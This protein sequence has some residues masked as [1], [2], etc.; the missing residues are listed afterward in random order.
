MARR[1]VRC[2]WLLAV[3]LTHACG[4]SAETDA[5]D[6]AASRP[7]PVDAAL[8]VPRPQDPAPSRLGDP[9]ASAAA[10][11]SWAAG[12]YAPMLQGEV[13]EAL[14][15]A[16]DATAS[17]AAIDRELVVCQADEGP[18]DAAPSPFR[19]VSVRW[20]EDHELDATLERGRRRAY[21]GVPLLSLTSGAVLQ[22]TLTGSDDARELST[23][24]AR[25]PLK[26]RTG[27]LSVEC[28]VVPAKARDE[29]VLDALWKTDKKLAALAVTSTED[30]GDGTSI[31]RAGT[32]A[33]RT[34][35]DAAALV[36]WDDPRVVRRRTR[37]REIQASAGH[38]LAAER[39]ED[40]LQPVGEWVRLGTSFS[41][42]VD[43]M[44]CE[45]DAGAEA[46]ADAPPYT[47]RITVSIQNGE[48]EA[49]DLRGWRHDELRLGEVTL[50]AQDGVGRGCQLSVDD[51]AAP[52]AANSAGTV[53]LTITPPYSATDADPGLRATVPVRLEWSRRRRAK[54]A[55]RLAGRDKT[56]RSAL[57]R[58]EACNG[59]AP[60]PACG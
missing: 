6:E 46:P 42:R 3:A 51:E 41:A 31:E 54:I 55:R 32:L 25:T 16:T 23:S 12:D 34:L 30:L 38:A 52:I 56:R 13:A 11:P 20:G 48:D 50:Q 39:A 15:A 45:F 33:E 22:M 29:A 8:A 53:R 40:V 14:W 37:I 1:L 9:V 28:R 27:A 36:G 2:W 21:F 57:P 59:P 58:P 35:S 26:L 7:S 4:D 49:M 43:E 10:A 5:K 24:F 60:P 47:C 44:T 18:G 17:A 19:R